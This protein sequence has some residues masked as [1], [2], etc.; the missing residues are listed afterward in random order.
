MLPSLQLL[1][2]ETLASPLA[3]TARHQGLLVLPPKYSTT[4]IYI[5]RATAARND[6]RKCKP[7]RAVYNLPMTS[8]CP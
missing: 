4:H 6:L 8:Y 2:P 1:N 7:N 3:L 5:I